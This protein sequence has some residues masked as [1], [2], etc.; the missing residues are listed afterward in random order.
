[1]AIVKKSQYIF[2]KSVELI[3]G[4]KEHLITGV[5][6]YTILLLFLYTIWE[7]ACGRLIVHYGECR[8][9]ES[10]ELLEGGGAV[11]ERGLVPHGVCFY[12][13]C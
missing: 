12:R 2:S 6:C 11:F 10:I 1:M 8:M 3:K 13:I 5:Q 7:R 4:K 9:I